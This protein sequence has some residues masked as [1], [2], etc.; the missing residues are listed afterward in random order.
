LIR[1]YEDEFRGTE[2]VYDSE[3]RILYVE[4]MMLRSYLYARMRGDVA[5]FDEYIRAFV[6][7]EALTSDDADSELAELLR[8][9]YGIE[10]R[11]DRSLGV[12]LDRDEVAAVTA[13]LEEHR[14]GSGARVRARNDARTVLTIYAI[15]EKNNEFG[16][17][18]I[19]GFR[20][21]W[22]TMDTSTGRAV[23]AALRG[24]YP[25]TCCIRADFL[26]DFLALRPGRNAVDETFT[27]MFPSLTGVSLSYHLDAD[28]GQVTRQFV[29]EHSRMQAG[30]LKAALRRHADLMK[31]DPGRANARAMRTFFEE[32]LAELE[33]GSA[34]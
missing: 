20:T 19:F 28:V 8:E 31:T 13:K 34:E 29:R 30:R 23:N 3:E 22:L 26:S 9:E 4:E 5:S 6:S 2:Q 24:R 11:D 17:A 21:W 1:S 27:Q 12:S 10:F 7:P 14:S 33:T 25:K 18:G 15:R 32:E 16:E